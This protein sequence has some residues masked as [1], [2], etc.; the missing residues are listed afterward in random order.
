MDRWPQYASA[1]TTMRSKTAVMSNQH[2]L[3]VPQSARQV[4]NDN[5]FLNTDI[6][7]AHQAGR[8]SATV[9][10][11][12]IH[13][14]GRISQLL[15]PIKSIIPAQEFLRQ[16]LHNASVLMFESVQPSTRGSYWT[17]WNHWRKWVPLAGTNTLMSV[18]TTG[19]SRRQR[20]HVHSTRELCS[21]VPRS[22]E[23]K[24]RRKRQDREQLF[25]RSKVYVIQL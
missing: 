20:K 15:P 19:F 10:R 17:G 3:L 11:E 14:T 7:T 9:S 12:Q 18:K 8:A 21:V 4:L 6:T 16:T 23:D 13:P 24:R 2:K 1:L 5:T 25:I 22:P